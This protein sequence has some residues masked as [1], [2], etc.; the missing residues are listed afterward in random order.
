M[1]D[2]FNNSGK[3]D[4]IVY[5]QLKELGLAQYDP[6]YQNNTP[7]PQQPQYNTPTSNTPYPGSSGYITPAP[8]NYPQVQQANPPQW[9]SSFLQAPMNI[10]P[11]E[12]PVQ[13]VNISTQSVTNESSGFSIHCRTE[14]PAM[15][16]CESTNS[17]E[18]AEEDQ[19]SS[20]QTVIRKSNKKNRNKYVQISTGCAQF[21]R[22]IE[23]SDEFSEVLLCEIHVL[24]ITSD[25][26][27]LPIS[28]I[29]N[30]DPSVKSK[31]SKYGISFLSPGNFDKWCTFVSHQCTS[32]TPVKVRM[33]YYKENNVWHCAGINYDN[34]N[35]SEQINTLKPFLES[36]K[37]Y[38]NSSFEEL[39]LILY[40]LTA[41][42]FTLFK[43]EEI[44]EF[45]N[46]VLVTPDTDK[47]KSLL[48]STFALDE[49]AF[50]ND[51][52]KSLKQLPAYKNNGTPVIVFSNSSAQN[53]SAL[54]YIL[55][56]DN[57][58]CYP[59]LLS[60]SFDNLYKLDGS[61]NFL[62]LKISGYIKDDIGKITE[63]FRRELLANKNFV[64]EIKSHIQFYSVD[65]SE[66]SLMFRVQK[67]YSFMLALIKTI[68]SQIKDIDT[69]ALC[70]RYCSFLA[71]GDSVNNI[72]LEKIKYILTSDNDFARLDKKN[73]SDLTDNFLYFSDK[74]ITLNASTMSRIA[75]KFGFSKPNVFSDTLKAYELL[76]TDKNSNLKVVN[77]GG[78]LSRA[79]SLNMDNLFSFGD[80]IPDCQIQKKPMYSIPI[81]SLSFNRTVSF[82]IDDHDNNMLFISGQSGSGKTNLCNIFAE[83]AAKKNMSV[84]II[85]NINS[86]FNLCPNAKEYVIS[87]PQQI[88]FWNN[89][90]KVGQITK[91]TTPNADIVKPDDILS[92]FLNGHKFLEKPS[93]R[94]HTLLIL[95]E[96]NEFSWL[97]NSPIRELLRKGRNYDISVVLSTQYLNSNNA[98]NIN[99]IL[100]QCASFCFFKEAVIPKHLT[101]TIPQIDLE[102]Y[103]AILTGNFMVNST[104]IKRPLHVKFRHFKD[105]DL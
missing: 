13:Q 90:D 70:E 82:S 103:E 35:F 80:F 41:K 61:Q 50:F 105:F 63:I 76:D 40:G 51:Y 101:K 56:S 8:V 102:R 14:I 96:V 29:S 33:G 26:L 4:Y 25:T 65:L 43:K 66:S 98:P 45:A 48:K 10:S 68:F 72:D 91:V 39:T 2:I 55:R 53:K 6:S 58:N 46:I 32:A 38:N 104:F 92:S 31:L 78:N 59:L 79:Y 87:D 64:Q 16:I 100:K 99:D 18:T 37:K 44:A 21:S 34:S 7:Y 77:F 5:E 81:G 19:S 73:R 67:L 30:H 86:I 28:L 52:T 88:I 27:L 94:T 89:I 97:E 93:E 12:T 1:S 3:S 62:L 49:T 11:M 85:G 69:D 71:E 54:E 95:D 42:M 47:I 22:L 36:L 24:G 57:L 60:G 9:N 84:I 23:R 74:S 17:V 83:Q 75:D 20:A 15:Y